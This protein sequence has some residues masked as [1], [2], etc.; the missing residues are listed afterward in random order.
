[1]PVAVGKAAQ[2]IFTGGP[3]DAVIAQ[4]GNPTNTN[5]LLYESCA[6]GA[7]DEVT[8]T[9]DPADPKRTPRVTVEHA[10]EMIDTYGRENPWVM[11]TILGMFPPTGFSAL[12]G[13]ADV[14]QAMARHYRADQYQFAPV[15]LG[16]DV[17]RQGD[18]SSVIARRQGVASFPLRSMRIPDTVQVSAQVSM[19][20]DQHDAAAMF[21]DET[22][23]YGAGVVDD[24]RRRGY[25][26]LGVQF[27]GRPSDARFFDKRSEM[28]F[29]LCE[30]IKAGGAL[31]PDPELKAELV[32]LRFVYQGDK[33][34]VVPKDIIKKEL[35]RSPDKSDALALTF[36]FPVAA[37]GKAGPA[38]PQQTQSQYDPYA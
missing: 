13:L 27:G 8:I 7:W 16:V 35:G 17:A 21:V 22:G 23:G 15:I 29:L 25:S 5:G 30:W 32:A 18:D 1:M 26:P 33:F 2:Q 20:H 36:A 38:S 34:R 4:A 19:E 28:L 9:A 14:E 12:I 10:Q 11:A 37:K 31:A 6:S 24:L 3:A